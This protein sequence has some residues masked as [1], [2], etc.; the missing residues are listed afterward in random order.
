[1]GPRTAVGDPQIC[2]T[3][4]GEHHYMQT[5]LHDQKTI[6]KFQGQPI[7]F[8]FNGVTIASPSFVS[9]TEHRY[10]WKNGM[11]PRNELPF[12]PDH[13]IPKPVPKP[14][15]AL[16]SKNREA[17]LRYISHI[18]AVSGQKGHNAAFRCACRIAKEVE[19]MAEGLAIFLQ[20]NAT[21]CEPPF[22]EAECLHKIEDAY[23][24]VRQFS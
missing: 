10:R 21:N 20:F 3:S 12:F 1:M 2:I 19:D 17:L 24:Q 18:H 15:P 9:E 13:L 5:L 6:L 4:R 23:K 7:D 16:V 11:L 14:M 8:K 22:S